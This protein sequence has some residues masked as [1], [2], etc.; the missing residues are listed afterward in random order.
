MTD[1]DPE[2]R[3]FLDRTRRSG[4]P[5][6]RQRSRVRRHVLAAASALWASQAA[7]ALG[8]AGAAK[9]VG[10]VVLVALPFA[11]TQLEPA[12]P[13]ALEPPVAQ[14]RSTA[15]RRPAGERV[16]EPA[17]E[18]PTGGP[19]SPDFVAARTTHEE[20]DPIRMA[21]P[22]RRHVVRRARSI[23]SGPVAERPDPPPP[24]PETARPAVDPLEAQVTLLQSS[25]HALRDGDLARACASARSH[26]ARYPASP[27]AHELAAIERQVEQA[28]GECEP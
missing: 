19:S 13:T 18:E 22:P 9:I 28:G 20:P 4:G 23:A 21:R 2:V 15:A 27:F 14:P 12:P 17:R 26:R 1:L 10:G 16:P 11:V 24:D 25:L 6:R 3:A 8:W 5:D 7:G